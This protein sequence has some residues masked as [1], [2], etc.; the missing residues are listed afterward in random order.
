MVGY[1]VC[2]IDWVGDDICIKFMI[3]GILLVEISSDCWFLQYD[4]IIVDEVYECSFNI[5]F[6]LGYFK[7]LLKKWL[8]LKLIVMLVMID[9]LWFVEYFDD[10]LVISVE[11]CIFLVEVCY[12]LLEGEGGGDEEGG[13]DGECIV[14]EVVVVVVDEI[15]WFDLCGDILLFFFGECEICDV[16]QFLEW[17]K[18][19]E[20]EVL[21]LYVWLLVKDQ[22]QVFNLGSKWCI[23]LVIN[24]VE[25]FLIVLCICYVVDFGLVWVKCYSL[26][27]KLDCLYIEV[28][29]QVSVN[30]C[31]GCCGCVLEGICY[32]L[33]LEVEF[34][35]WVEFIDFE[36]CCFSLVGVI[37]WMLQ[38]GLG[39]IEDFLFF[40]VLD[41]CVIVDGWQQLG[42]LGVV[43]VE[44]W[45]ILVG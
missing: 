8:D 29:L 35:L 41:E 24:V 14:N 10:V 21:L 40:E 30:Q 25:I 7:Q 34:L 36:I 2:F 43:D 32:C 44:C 1:Q 15:I 13:C 12:C 23:V 31:K 42:E 11:G 6:L 17:C 19:C 16:Y 39:W 4:M 45:L 28:V 37:L 33:Y 22:D 5:D 26:W 18:Y 27:Q 20:I 9:M 38:F 3:D